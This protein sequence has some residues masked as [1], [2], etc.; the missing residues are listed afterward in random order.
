MTEPDPFNR[1][2]AELHFAIFIADAGDIHRALEDIAVRYAH[3]MAP[4]NLADVL[5]RAAALAEALQFARASRSGA[6][7]TPRASAA[8][9]TAL[10][11]RLGSLK[12]L[13]S[14]R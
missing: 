8:D 10:R 11:S 9:A 6:A 3:A 12:R 14:P 2:A 13:L 7:A 1:L 4:D 5:E